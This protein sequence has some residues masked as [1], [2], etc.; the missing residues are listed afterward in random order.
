[1]KRDPVKVQLFIEN[2]GM[3]KSPQTAA[4][5]AGYSNPGREG[6]ALMKL[7]EVVSEIRKIQVENRK[8]SAMS[9]KDVMENLIDAFALARTLS[10]PQAM[11]RAMSEVN[12]MS[13]YYAPE[14]KIIEL[15]EGAKRLEAEVEGFTK[16][17]LL[18]MLVKEEETPFLEAQQQEDGSFVVEDEAA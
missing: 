15:Q 16:Q 8:N 6:R 5:A 13:G 7:P 9:R 17:E 14:K 3:G 2:A 11:I 18:E 1:M 10:D 4:R 12:R